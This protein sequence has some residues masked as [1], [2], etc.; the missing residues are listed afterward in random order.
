MLLIDAVKNWP[1]MAK[2]GKNCHK[3]RQNYVFWPF[4][5]FGGLTEISAELFRPILTEISA[6]ISVSVVHYSSGFS[7]F[8]RIFS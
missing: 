7:Y 4:R 2:I 6:E 8:F 5:R 1:K 3:I